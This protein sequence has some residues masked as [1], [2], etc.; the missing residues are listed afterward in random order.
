L[1]LCRANPHNQSC[2]QITPLKIR[3]FWQKIGGIRKNILH[4]FLRFSCSLGFF[5]LQALAFQQQA[6]TQSLQK[7]RA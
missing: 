6:A 2:L 1:W 7:N 4:F 5:Y 3:P